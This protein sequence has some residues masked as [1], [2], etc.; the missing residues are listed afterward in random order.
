MLS[1]FVGLFALLFNIQDWLLNCATVVTSNPTLQ[2]SWSLKPVA[3]F[4]IFKQNS[5]LV[6][7]RGG[8]S[9]L[10]TRYLILD[11]RLL[12]SGGVGVA[13]NKMVGFTEICDEW[14]CYQP[15]PA[16]TLQ[17]FKLQHKQINDQVSCPKCKSHAVKALPCHWDYSGAQILCWVKSV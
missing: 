12:S 15:Y 3:R 9:L 4:Q 8:F 17:H 10:D 14:W 1:L 13:S 7:G 2:S 5:H 11:S 6:G 16:M